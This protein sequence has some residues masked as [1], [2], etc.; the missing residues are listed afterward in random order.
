MTMCVNSCSLLVLTPRGKIIGL[1]STNSQAP[2]E[3][4]HLGTDNGFDQLGFYLFN[5]DLVL[6]TRQKI[7]VNVMTII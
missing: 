7:D 2:R 4:P 5:F 3:T 1:E 6:H